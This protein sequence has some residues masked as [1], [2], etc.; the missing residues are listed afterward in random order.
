MLG[1]KKIKINELVLTG[2]KL[3]S[4]CVSLITTDLGPVVVS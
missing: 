3:T 1:R 2:N 4:N